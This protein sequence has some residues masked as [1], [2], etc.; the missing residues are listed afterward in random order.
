MVHS[1]RRR[2]FTLIELL[3]VIAII[4]ILIGLLL[5]AVQKVRESAQRISCQNNLH[6]IGIACANYES[7]ALVLPPGSDNQFYPATVY[8]LPYIE[9]GNVFAGLVFSSAANPPLWIS[10]QPG[11]NFTPTPPSLLCPAAPHTTDAPNVAVFQTAGTPGLD[12]PGS[13]GLSANGTYTVSAAGGA[14]LV[15][16]SCYLPMAGHSA[17]NLGLT[18]ISQNPY[19]GVFTYNSRNSLGKIP[20]GSSQTIIYGEAVGGNSPT[21]SGW[22]ANSWLMGPQFTDFGIC[23]DPA[24]PNCESGGGT[25]GLAFGIW[26]STHSGGLVYFTFGDGSVHGI[27]GSINQATFV[28]LAGMSDGQVVSFND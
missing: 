10:S 21:G 26:G 27:S 2:A 1:L 6:Q 28:Y 3:V 22:I 12:F 18:A 14:A 13:F 20:D 9:Q 15:G 11:S 24:D 16:R 7:G 4:A 8:L 19:A 17:G 23:P 5:P 25:F